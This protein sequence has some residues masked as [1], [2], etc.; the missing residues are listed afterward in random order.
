MSLFP[1][2]NVYICR[3]SSIFGSLILSGAKGR[4]KDKSLFFCNLNWP[5]YIPLVYKEELGFSGGMGLYLTV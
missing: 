5:V 1:I 2:H 4:A 3:T